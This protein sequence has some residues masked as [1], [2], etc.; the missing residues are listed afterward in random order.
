[1]KAAMIQSTSSVFQANSRAPALLVR[2]GEHV[3]EPN[4]Q[5]KRLRLTNVGNK[6]VV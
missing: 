4:E 1:M 3:P 2:P 6:G 5:N